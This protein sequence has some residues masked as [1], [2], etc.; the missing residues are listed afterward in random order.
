MDLVL[1]S[2][3]AYSYNWVVIK[4]N[5]LRLMPEKLKNVTHFFQGIMQVFLGFHNRI[6]PC[7]R[8]IYCLFDVDMMQNLDQKVAA[9]IL[10]SGSEKK[11]K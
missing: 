1:K 5:I 10:K 4:D 7:L 2:N 9:Y 3:A 11:N 8:N 6:A